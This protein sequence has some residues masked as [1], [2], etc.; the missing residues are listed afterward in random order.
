MPMC[1]LSLLIS[2]MPVPS[3]APALGPARAP[4]NKE[5]TF[6]DIPIQLTF[7][8]CVLEPP[9]PRA[10]LSWMLLGQGGA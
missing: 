2:E 5:F 10:L 8:S 7:P 6:S 1:V 4:S 3:T 9:F